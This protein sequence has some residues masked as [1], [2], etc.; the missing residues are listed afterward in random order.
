MSKFRMSN[1]SICLR[2]KSLTDISFT[3]PDFKDII[4]KISVKKISLRYFDV[5]DISTTYPSPLLLSN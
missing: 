4:F 1:V 5:R 3:W 2:E